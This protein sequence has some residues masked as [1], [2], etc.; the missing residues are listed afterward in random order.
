MKRS[1][2]VV[3]LAVLLGIVLLVVAGIY[4]A[5]KAES[6]PSF[7]PGHQAGSTTHHFKHGIAAIVVGLARFAF[8]WFASGPRKGAARAS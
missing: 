4:F 1:R 7:F 8:A 2:I 3:V 5:D 6:L